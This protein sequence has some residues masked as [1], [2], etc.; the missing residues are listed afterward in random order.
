MK[1]QRK[2]GIKEDRKNEPN[3]DRRRCSNK[4]REKERQREKREG[5]RINVSTYPTNGDTSKQSDFG[6]SRLQD[7][8]S[9]VQRVNIN[10]GLPGSIDGF[11]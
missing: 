1:Q 3:K 7:T 4:Q 2:N 8:F 6:Q 5:T 11:E 9:L 10:V